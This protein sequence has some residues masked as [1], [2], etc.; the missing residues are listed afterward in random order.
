EAGLRSGRLRGVVST[1]ALELGIDVGALD[2]AVIPG[3][4]GSIM[5]VCQQA[6]RVGRRAHRE[7]VVVLVAGDDALDQYHIQHP[8]AFFGAA[9]E[10]A[11]VDPSNASI[12]LG[13][14]VCAASER[15]LLG[16][17]LSL[18]PTN[19]GR[20]VERLAEAG[21]LA[22]APPWRALGRGVHADVSLRGT[23][24]DPY[25]LQAPG[26]RIGTIEPPYLQRECYPG[27]LYLHNG[28][29]YR[30]AGVDAAPRV[31]RLAAAAIQS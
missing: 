5:S 30:A 17:D 3:Y 7:A 11:A 28:R 12:L 6:G 9:M 4:P 23:S 15:P 31:A 19:A 26:A 2:V 10:Q 8:D 13:H 16:D 1:N 27:A 22:A 24:R 18:F 29:G 20:L 21:E 14:L 25:T